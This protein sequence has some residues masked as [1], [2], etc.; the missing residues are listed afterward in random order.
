MLNTDAGSVFRDRC[1]KVASIRRRSGCDR[2][3]EWGSMKLVFRCHDTSF[4]G[5]PIMVMFHT[6]VS[7]VLELVQGGGVGVSA[8]ERGCICRSKKMSAGGGIRIGELVFRSVP[9]YFLE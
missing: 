7:D 3:R 1:G 9:C 8:A 4:E 2:Y 5:Y 6:A